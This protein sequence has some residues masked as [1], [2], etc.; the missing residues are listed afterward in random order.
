ILMVTTVVPEVAKLY[1]DLKKELPFLTKILVMV[2]DALKNFWWL[3]IIGTIAAVLASRR[4]LATEKMQLEADRLKM[5]IPLFGVL[6][7]KVYMARFARTMN[8]LLASGI[9]MLQAL[10]TTRDAVGNKVIAA[11]VTETIAEVRGGKA[12]SVALSKRVHFLSL[13][14]QMTK[15]GEESGAIDDML[16]RCA[17]YFEDEVDEAVKNLSTTLEPVMM[18]VLGL[19][20][21][22]IIA[23]VLGPVYSLVGSG[24]LGK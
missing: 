2:A 21:G 4:L 14:P 16:G 24:D 20:V 17:T 1:V 12:L 15:V 19:I 22:V 11:D 9:P 3:F 23:A 5:K 8:T 10:E 13:V 18:I 6:F 7:T